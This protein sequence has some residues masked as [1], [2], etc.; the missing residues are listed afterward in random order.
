MRVYTLILHSPISV[1]SL[2]S[3]C[4]NSLDFAEIRFVLFVPLCD[5]KNAA[6]MQKFEASRIA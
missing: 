1:E 3:A 5:C 6:P 2:K 4:V